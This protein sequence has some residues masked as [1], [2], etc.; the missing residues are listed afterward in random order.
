MDRLA[1]I[2]VGSNISNYIPVRK[3]ESLVGPLRFL[4]SPKQHLRTVYTLVLPFQPRKV[5]FLF[6]LISERKEKIL[7]QKE[8]S[9][10][11]S[12]NRKLFPLSPFTCWSGRDWV[13]PPLPPGST[14]AC[15]DYNQST[16]IL[17]RKVILLRFFKLNPKYRGLGA[18]NFLAPLVNHPLKTVSNLPPKLF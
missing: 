3:V 1:R 2:A 4:F 15:V 17:Q 14:D 12:N 16:G 18:Q 13:E 11:I 7:P 9:A 5:F 6:S 8:K 10:P